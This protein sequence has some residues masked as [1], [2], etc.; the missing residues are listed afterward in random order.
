MII[1]ENLKSSS[2][3]VHF[4]FADVDEFFHGMLLR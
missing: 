1:G 3:C 2:L 4:G